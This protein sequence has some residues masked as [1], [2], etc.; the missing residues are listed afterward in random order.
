MKPVRVL[1]PIFM[2]RAPGCLRS[3]KRDSL[4][5]RTSMR[6]TPTLTQ[7]LP[8]T[9]SPRLPPTIGFSTTP[10]WCESTRRTRSSVFGSEAMSAS[11][12]LQ[13]TLLGLRAVSY[14]HSPTPAKIGPGMSWIS[15]TMSRRHE[16]VLAIDAVIRRMGWKVLLAYAIIYLVWGSTYLAIRVGVLEMPPLLMAAIRFLIAGLL[17]YG[18]TVARGERQPTVRQWAS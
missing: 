1:P 18:W 11:V 13:S 4:A 17:L 7:S 9:I 6:P 5:T 12:S 8:F 14:G 16:G 3:F 10:F 15:L 2:G